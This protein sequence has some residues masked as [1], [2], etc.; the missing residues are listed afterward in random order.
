MKKWTNTNPMRRL[1]SLALSMAMVLSVLPM[2]SIA[3]EGDGLCEHHT[4]HTADCGY[5]AAVEGQDCGHQHDDSCGYRE[6]SD[7]GHQHDESCGYQEASPC[8]HQ[9]TE[10]CGEDGASCAHVHDESCGYAEAS[11]CTHSHDDLCGYQEASPCKH[12]HD[13]SCGYVEAVEG[14]PCTYQC[15]LC[16]GA[17]E[18][19]LLLGDTVLTD[20]EWVDDWGIIDPETGIAHLPFASAENMARFDD[21]VP[22]LPAAIEMNGETLTLGDWLC[23][24]YPVETGAYEGEYVFETTL[25]E[26]YTLPDC[27]NVLSLTVVLGDPEGEPVAM[28]AV[29]METP[30]AED[31]T[32]GGSTVYAYELSTPAHLYWFANQINTTQQDISAVLTADITVNQNVLN[33]SGGL[34]SGSFEAWTPIGTV[35]HNFRGKFDGQGHTI[36]GL[37]LND[38]ATDNVGLF[39]IVESP[40]SIY[41]VGVVDSYFAGGQNV[42]GLCGKALSDVRIES[43][44]TTA[45]VS[46]TSNVG[47]FCGYSSA[48]INNCYSAGRI[49]SSYGAFL[50]SGNNV[51]FCYALSDKNLDGEL[52]SD[53]KYRTM[54]AFKS[55][56]VTYGLT[57]NQA[58]PS[59]RQTIGTH[60]FPQCTTNGD[61]VYR[62]KKDGNVYYH[63]HTDGEA[64][65]SYCSVPDFYNNEYLIDNMGELYWF[66]NYVNSGHPDANAKVRYD[67][68]VD[69]NWTPI[70]SETHPFTGKFTYPEGQK[71]ISGIPSDSSLFGATGS[72]AEIARITV[73]SGSLC[74]TSGGNL[75]DCHVSGGGMLVSGAN[76][77][78]VSDSSAAGGTLIAN[79]SGTVKNSRAPGGTLVQTNTGTI[80]DC[81]DEGSGATL[82]ANNAEGIVTDCYV[83]GAAG[84]VLVGANSGTIQKSYAAGG[85]TLCTTNS[86]GGKIINCYATGTGSVTLCGSN[87]GVIANCFAAGGSGT[88]VGSGST[89][90]NCYALAGNTASTVGG[91]SIT[92][93]D[94]ANGKVAYWLNQGTA[95]YP[96]G[97]WG[98]TIG[99]ESLPI[100]GGKAVYY[101]Q[102][103]DPEYHNHN[104]YCSICTITPEYASNQWQITNVDELYWYAQYINGTISGITDKTKNAIL[105]NDITVN[106]NVLK[107]DGTLSDAYA[108]FTA[109]TPIGISSSNYDG[110]FDGNHHTI[111][112]LYV[113]APGTS[114]VG[115]F[116]CIIG[117]GTIKN[118]TIADSYFEGKDKVGGVCGETSG[119]VSGCSYS[120]AVTGIEGI[121]GICGQSQGT[122]SGCTN[123]GKVTGNN[124][125]GGIC[126]YAFQGTVSGCINYGAV[127][128]SGYV[129]G[130]CGYA[131]YGEVSGCINYGAVN[132]TSNFVGG[133]C[134]VNSNTVSGC[135]NTGA[136]TGSSTS[137]YVG[138]VCGQNSGT[139]SNCANS[140]GI[141]GGSTSSYVGGVC[142]DNDNTINECYSIGGVSGD[143]YL[144]GVCGNNSGTVRNCYH[145]SEVHSGDAVGYNN[146]GTVDSVLG[147]TTKEFASGEVAYL[148]NGSTNAGTWKQNLDTDTRDETPNFTGAAVYKATSGACS[149][150]YTNNASLVKNHV[151]ENHIC[152]FC[153]EQ[154]QFPITVSGI[155][156]KNKTFN[157]NNAAELDCSN[158]VLAGVAAG[159][160]ISVTATGTFA[161]ANVGSGKEVTITGLTLT[162]NDAEKYRLAESGQQTSATASITAKPLSDSDITV[163]V[164]DLTYT[165]S[166]QSPTVTVKYGT[167]TLVE[168]TDYT[169]SGNTGTNVNSYTLTVT[170][171]GN[172]ADFT[173][174]DWKINKASSSISTAPTAVSGLTYSGQPQTLITA[175]DTSHGTM[176]YSLEKSGT[177]EE[178][179]P[180]GTSAGE[181]TVWYKIEGDDNHLDS[182]PASVGSSIA[183]KGLTIKA[184]DHTITYGDA[185]SNSGVT[186]DGFVNGET[187]RVLGGS[188]TYTYNYSQYG[189]VGSSYDITPSGLTSDNYAITFKPGKL[190]V[191]KKQ[192]GITWGD[193]QFT[194]NGSK[195]IPTATP[196]GMVNDDTITLTVSGDQT[197]AGTGYTATVS[198]IN[199]VKA[200]NYALPNS[201]TTT[202]SIAKKEVTITGTTVAETKVYNGNATA[203]ITSN[204]SLSDNYDGNNLTIVPGSAAYDNKNVG[205]SKSVTFSGFSL[206]GSAAGNYALTGQ[207]A[208]VKAAITVKSVTLTVTVKDKDF[209]GT[210]TAE[211]DNVSADG[212]VA[213]DDVLLVSGEATFPQ[214]TPGENLSVTFTEFT[215]EGED[216]GNYSIT[217]PTPTGVTGIINP[218]D[219]YLDLA[220]NADFASQTE[221]WVDGVAYPIQTEGNRRY[222]SLP[223]TGDLLTGYTYKKGNSTPSH[224][225]YP[226][227]MTV[228]RITR[229]TTGATLTR[230]SAFDDL[231]RYSGCAIRITGKR[232]IRMITSLT[233]DNK[234]ALKGAGLAGYTLEEYG[235]VAQWA[236]ELGAQSLTLS[237]GKSNYAY[238]RGKADPVFA[239][240]GDLTQ[241]TNVLVWDSL[242]NMQLGQDIV[243][244]PYIKLSKDGQTV[245]LYGGTVSRSIGYIAYQNR[246]VFQPGTAAYAYVWDIIHAVYGKTYDKDYKG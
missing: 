212:F 68:T 15:D 136:V 114:C 118:L 50:G 233:K 90:T 113:N 36:S 97:V 110:T 14:S 34:N 19:E 231:L 112:G 81:H 120:G 135:T 244:R 225:N 187:E 246:N 239:N 130:I 77:G 48:N 56:E 26:G 44:Y 170:G 21:I 33:T 182:A 126:G 31:Y 167:I 132:G 134:G 39:G 159:D 185:P 188:L 79:N 227:S 195:Q 86:S 226:T 12:E 176:V 236:D 54:D 232:G 204:G 46:G 202:F 175:G 23:P 69:S 59:W 22:M 60:T 245:T 150:G 45:T 67:I 184:K 61:I 179:I 35:D 72:G 237:N 105:M 203:Q 64:S 123:R 6:A 27:T 137:S 148:L 102:G 11:D 100:L 106:S 140:G 78:T 164:S 242:T 200:G 216:A 141:T 240:V 7:C 213:G 111:S 155:T 84:T 122:V 47:T 162:G 180:T 5:V 152:V 206:G 25:P 154:D 20:W 199:G 221:V 82:C 70:G 235:T 89:I 177:Y 115:F 66:A 43:C 99:A 93:N 71:T 83:S 147:K 205:E 73:T 191:Q 127:N 104:G 1:L 215:L 4:E 218:S 149:P 57:K 18:P 238:K 161:D 189:D 95:V 87:S 28:L 96:S 210:T 168:N 94:F 92:A 101:K 9:H 124:R 138:G 158:V 166:P 209:D 117:E 40:A 234:N 190:T 214:K 116:G 2:P 76:S 58:T 222:A 224:E 228:Y 29:T 169:L 129:G 55:G 133:V 8:T 230:I 193:T 157:G 75:V 201:V 223:K 109:W 42:G 51:D 211:I 183:K 139:I 91:E 30:T 107:A 163:T 146:N 65:C 196:T 103:G 173:T 119:T 172:Y 143:S 49:D 156:A 220:G 41:R 24:D 171:T 128:G 10:E 32:I 178:A 85:A 186:Y 229:G 62:G 121:G 153:D 243:M 217:N 197:N 88:T 3:A 131:L 63:N 16:T 144:G 145:N 17:S 165:G 198:K 207:P 219:R 151:F 98:Q 125:V 208:S 142:G 53:L 192:I 241:Y 74:A 52:D 108:S 37:Y 174:K 160:D 38:S 194:Y 80:T 13:G 181:Y